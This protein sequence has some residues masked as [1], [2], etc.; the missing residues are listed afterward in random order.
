MLENCHCNRLRAPHKS[1]GSPRG[2][3]TCTSS[4][5][6]SL[7]LRRCALGSSAT[8]ADAAHRRQDVLHV[9]RG[10]GPAAARRSRTRGASLGSTWRESKI[11]HRERG[12]N[13]Q[14]GAARSRALARPARP[15]A[16]RSGVHPAP[17]RH[18][19]AR[20]AS[21]CTAALADRAAAAPINV[22][23]VRADCLI[24]STV[25]GQSSSSYVFAQAFSRT[26]QTERDACAGP[27][28]PLH[29]RQ[30]AARGRSAPAWDPRRFLSGA[31]CRRRTRVTAVVVYI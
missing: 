4:L 11:D 25:A 16:A 29:S 2:P 8:S 19:P 22:C 1:D 15:S 7:M 13:A 30:H 5:G 17:R 27:R 10:A 31:F 12:A 20:G 23:R 26:T 24:R 3:S 14:L 9:S 18:A 21:D 28:P 6:G